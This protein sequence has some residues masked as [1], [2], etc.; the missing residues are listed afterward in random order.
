MALSSLTAALNEL[1][2]LRQ[3]APAELTR[4]CAAAGAE[5]RMLADD[6]E[7]FELVA[8]HAQG[9]GA[10]PEDVRQVFDDLARFQRF[11]EI[12]FRVLV[13]AGVEKH[14]AHALLRE[15]RSVRASVGA[16]RRDAAE[17]RVGVS[18]LRNETCEMAER[19]H[20]L[21]SADGRREELQSLLGRAGKVLGG[22][23][24]LIVNVE[25]LAVLGPAY[26]AAS[27]ALAVSLIRDGVLKG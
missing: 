2:A 20:G 17:I 9:E 22:G 5:L 10:L 18:K 24:L 26:S 19:L 23:A 3:P 12:E 4:A 27:G 6:G 11:L 21:A 1:L 14:A 15:A 7:F 13:E 25:A 8:A 16:A